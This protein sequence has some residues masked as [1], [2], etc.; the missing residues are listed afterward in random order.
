[1]GRPG[2]LTVRRSYRSGLEDK[3]GAQLEAAGIPCEYE[4]LKLRY[5]VPA[6]EHTYTPDWPCPHNIIIET[7][8]W[9]QDASERQKMVL[10][11]QCHPNLDI[12]FV[13]QN[14]KKPIYKGSPTSYAKWAESHGFPWADKGTIPPAWI[15]EMQK[16]KK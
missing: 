6:R 4:S 5:T 1:M 12:R 16:G 3:V 13:F 8:G 2:K 9:F 11:K 7:K 14:A 15:I 10:V